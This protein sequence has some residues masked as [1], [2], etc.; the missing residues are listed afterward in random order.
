MSLRRWCFF[1]SDKVEDIVELNKEMCTIFNMKEHKLGVDALEESILLINPAMLV[2]DYFDVIY[3]HQGE[4]ITSRLPHT[5][6]GTSYVHMK[7]KSVNSK[8]EVEYCIDF[9]YTLADI[10]RKQFFELEKIDQPFITE[11]FKI[12]FTNEF[13]RIAYLQ[14]GY[15][16][17][18]SI[19]LK[20]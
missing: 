15:I 9:E 18:W 1:K 8:E 14:L 17:H 7:W 13:L 19:D 3:Q 4:I 20:V 12:S 5:V 16:D 10:R 2:S 6:N 11:S